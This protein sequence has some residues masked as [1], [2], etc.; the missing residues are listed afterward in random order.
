M[1][2]SI[3]RLSHLALALSSAAFILVLTLTGIVLAFDPV[4]DRM[5][6]YERVQDFPDQTLA[7]MI[8][9]VQQRYD[10]VLT[11]SVDANGYLAI[12]AFTEEGDVEDFY[13]HP[14]TGEKTGEFIEQSELMKFAATLHRS[15]FLKSPGRIF[16]GINSFL[17]FLIAASGLVLIVKRQQGWKEVFQKIIR[18]GVFQ[19]SHIYL[20][21]IALVPLVIISITGVYLSL[22]RFS[23]IP[24]SIPEHDI[25]SE[26]IASEP[27]VPLDQF[28]WFTSIPLEDLRSLEFPFSPDPID[29]YQLSLRDKEVVINQYTG[30]TLSEINY[31]VV[32]LFSEW[33]TLL[34]TGRGTV[35]WSLVLALSCLAIFYFMVSGFA[36]WW[37]RRS[38]RIRNTFRKKDCSHILLVGSETGSTL[39]FAQMLHKHLT[40]AGI[41]SF[42]AELNRFGSY[43]RMDHLIVLTATYGQ[44]EAPT[45]ARKFEQLIQS[46]HIDRPF[47]FSV[48][49]CGSLAY[50]DF[51]KY[52]LDVDRWL[53]N[54]PEASRL[55]QPFT[56]NKRSLESFAQWAERWGNLT[57]T[58]VAI[59]KAPALP[60]RR[61]KP[62]QFEVIGKAEYD[63]T[64]VL[65]L[66]SVKAKSF[67]SGDLLAVFP[68]DGS[69]ERLYSMGCT[70]AGDVLL[71]IKRHQHG[72]CSGY[73][74][75]LKS[76]D[77]L[78]ANIVKNKHFHFSKKARTVVLISSGTGIAPYIGMLHNNAKGT[79]THLYWGGR[80]P[81]AFG[82]YAPE[83]KR[84]K[85]SGKL[86]RLERAFSRENEEKTYVQD[87]L[88]QDG[89]MIAEALEE[90]GT[91]MICGSIAMQSGVIQV[92]NKIVE[93]YTIRALSHYQNKGQILMDCY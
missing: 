23:I 80:T 49:G 2:L 43:P 57:N 37:K 91:L 55:T 5:V 68:D 26:E 34:H 12:S 86:Q 54:L 1:T 56:I 13:I 84:L 87:L 75:C 29:Y 22:L 93:Q 69:H 24:D 6:G 83:I 36:M 30:E 19:Y 74:D 76:G 25:A 32:R 52:A 15:L 72:V 81:E 44:G 16:I 89:V 85:E 48:V 14:V 62:T 60:K 28:T 21:R 66:R 38:S 88:L 8:H 11:L 61:K 18:E 59:S 67:T 50:A 78:V 20:G 47:D 63:D 33:S 53:G 92:L 41:K 35:G 7:D 3:W 27:I 70:T 73:L 45:N 9:V 71:S 64:F 4:A 46:A 77:S 51:C 17:L 90:G 42:I 40:K 31:P 82:L 39:V 58:E 10:E 79:D 65:T